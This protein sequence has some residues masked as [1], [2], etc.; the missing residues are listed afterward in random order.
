MLSFGLGGFHLR[1]G[2]RTGNAR[3]Y[4][5]RKTKIYHFHL[6][7]ISIVALIS[8]APVSGALVIEKKGG[9][10]INKKCE[11]TFPEQYCK[12]SITSNSYLRLTLH[13]SKLGTTAFGR[14]WLY[15]S[16]GSMI[17]SSPVGSLRLESGLWRLLVLI[18]IQLLLVL[19]TAPF[20]RVWVYPIITIWRLC[21]YKSSSSS[22]EFRNE[23]WRGMFFR[24]L[25][26]PPLSRS[27]STVKSPC[28]CFTDPEP[29]ITWASFLVQSPVNRRL[30]GVGLQGMNSNPTDYERILDP[31]NHY[32]AFSS[33]YIVSAFSYR[34]RQT[35]IAKLTVLI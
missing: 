28:F 11:H 3:G 10:A 30:L 14:R 25:R 34:E 23:I 13:V 18:T 16:C 22:H 26:M 12:E 31:V 35:R 6:K 1:K 15:Q 4:Q 24:H 5:D 7:I 21:K 2:G 9:M 33:K 32:C 27:A 20:A 17:I 19:W 29:S 8:N